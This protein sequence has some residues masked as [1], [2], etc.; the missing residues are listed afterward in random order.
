MLFWGKGKVILD[1]GTK[2]ISKRC[3]W[4]RG[5]EKVHDKGLGL[6]EVT[7]YRGARYMSVCMVYCA[8]HKLGDPLPLAKK[9]YNF[10][11]LRHG[12]LLNRLNVL[13][14]MRKVCR[15]VFITLI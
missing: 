5:R 14:K 11:R 9:S 10:A 12:H 3:G 1:G 4:S 6:L 13:K 7:T 2:R 8:E 15:L